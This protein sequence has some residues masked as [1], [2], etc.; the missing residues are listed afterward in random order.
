M[1]NGLMKAMN[2]QHI[3]FVCLFSCLLL[4]CGECACEGRRT[5]LWNGHFPPAQEIK[6]RL[7]GFF[8]VVCR[9]AR[10]ITCSV[11][12]HLA[13]PSMFPAFTIPT[14]VIGTEV[15]IHDRQAFCHGGTASAPFRLGLV[16]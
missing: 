12:S 4:V 1:L 5:T 9:G 7:S 13:G 10:T 11:L 15:F 14:S 6:P 3:L 8:V 16:M 2:R